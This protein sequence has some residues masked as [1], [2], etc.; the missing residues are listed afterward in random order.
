MQCSVNQ[1]RTDRFLILLYNNKINNLHDLHKTKLKL[2][3]SDVKKKVL[4]IFSYKIH[5]SFFRDFTKYRQHLNFIDTLT[6][7]RSNVF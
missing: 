2:S 1:N 3:L 5:N 4:Q 6:K 7:K